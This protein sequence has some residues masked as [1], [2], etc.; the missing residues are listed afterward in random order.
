MQAAQGLALEVFRNYRDVALGD[1][2]S[3]AWSGM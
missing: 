3:G 2:I 1:M